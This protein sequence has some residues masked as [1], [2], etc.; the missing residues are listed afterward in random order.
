[1]MDCRRVLRT[2]RLSPFLLW[3]QQA[4]TVWVNSVFEANTIAHDVGFDVESSVTSRTAKRDIVVFAQRSCP[5]ITALLEMKLNR[6]QVSFLRSQE[7]EL[8]VV[9]NEPS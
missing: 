2:L 6:R 3:G 1:M 9:L 8:V 5:T 7:R 4:R